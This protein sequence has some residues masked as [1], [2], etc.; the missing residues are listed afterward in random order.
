MCVCVSWGMTWYD[1]TK[2]RTGPIGFHAVGPKTWTKFL[3]HTK[4]VVVIVVGRQ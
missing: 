1:A 4:R 3:K 2:P